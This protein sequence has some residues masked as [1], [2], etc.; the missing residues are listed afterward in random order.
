MNYDEVKKCFIAIKLLIQ[1]LLSRTF[2]HR[3][4]YIHTCAGCVEYWIILLVLCL[5]FFP[6][7][8]RI[9]YI[10]TQHVSESDLRSNFRFSTCVEA[11][12]K[13]MF[14]FVLIISKEIFRSFACMV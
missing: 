4:I 1:F 11:S 6:V 2:G 7:C 9:F 5:G 14:V 12:N 10:F 3:Y 8:E 13:F